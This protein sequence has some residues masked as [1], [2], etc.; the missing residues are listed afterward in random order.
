MCIRDSICAVQKEFKTYFN[1]DDSFETEGSSFDH[2]FKDGEEIEAG[3]ILI[4]AL[5]TPGH[6]L[7]CTSF[8]VNTHHLFVGDT[9]FTPDFGTGRCDFP[10]GDARSLFSS[11]KKKI[12]SLPDNTKIYVGH[13]YQPGGRKL[14]FMSTVGEQKSENAHLNGSTSEESFVVFR[15]NRDQQLTSPQLLLASVQFNAQGGRLP[16]PESNGVSY[17]KIPIRY[18]QWSYELLKMRAPFLIF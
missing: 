11:V 7:T 8:L 13:D 18:T 3:T 14:R 1:F 4:K 9:L 2:L 10:G 16:R 6:T 12:Y 17:L 15:K 5:H